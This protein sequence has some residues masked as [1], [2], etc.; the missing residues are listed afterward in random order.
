MYSK[1][2]IGPTI[3]QIDILAELTEESYNDFI[4]QIESTKE[5]TLKMKFN[6]NNITYNWQKIENTTIVKSKDAEDASVTE[7][8]FDKNNKAIYIIAMGGN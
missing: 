5:E 1:W 2:S 3:Y 4:K 6:P 7:I 8:Y